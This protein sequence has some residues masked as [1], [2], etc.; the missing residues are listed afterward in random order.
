MR[1]ARRHFHDELERLERDVLAL[2][3]EAVRALGRASEALERYDAELAESVVQGDD[4]I[5]RH[6]VEIDRHALELLALQTPVAVDLRLISSILH[7][8]LHLERVG[9]A[10]VSISKVVRVTQTLRRT[11]T[12]VAHL[13]EM[14][15]VVG[16]MVRTAMDAFARRDLDLALTLPGMDDPVDRLNRGMYGEVAACSSDPELLEWALRMMTVSRHLERAGDHAV[17]IAEQ[18]A[19]LLTGQFREFA[20]AS[21]PVR[22]D[23]RKRQT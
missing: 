13:V 14:A 22:L 8:N 20:D 19:F 7:I 5:D 3:D 11:T 2:G 18:V 23:E 1:Q 6:Y 10:A 21:H 17:D 16:H 4:E 15:D 9:D 12:I